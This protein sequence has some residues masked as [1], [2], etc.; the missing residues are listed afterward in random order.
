[1]NELLADL[2]HVSE[3]TLMGC[4][5]VDDFLVRLNTYSFATPA[6][7]LTFDTVVHAS[8]LQRALPYVESSIG[9][10]RDVDPSTLVQA[11]ML[12]FKK[13]DETLPHLESYLSPGDLLPPLLA[14]FA[15]ELYRYHKPAIN[16]IVSAYVKTRYDLL[17][18]FVHALVL[19]DHDMLDEV[20]RK[21]P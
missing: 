17:G 11:Q 4:S 12:A 1:M 3:W 6:D 18:S 13:A 19:G 7:Q 21:W 14:A 9:L 10:A 15:V 2:P 20:A 5:I 8:T 16:T